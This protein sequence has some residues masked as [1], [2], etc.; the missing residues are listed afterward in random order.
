MFTEKPRGAVVL[1]HNNNFRLNCSSSM[2]SGTFFISLKLFFFALFPQKNI[3]F[4]LLWGIT[5][6]QAI[7]R[8]WTA[9]MHLVGILRITYHELDVN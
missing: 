8:M 4:A 7:H 9:D 5:A 3:F 2:E 6:A 1:C